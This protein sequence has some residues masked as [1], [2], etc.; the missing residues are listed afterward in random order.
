M[1]EKKKYTDEEIKLIL[2]KF[3]KEADEL[4]TDYKKLNKINT[5]K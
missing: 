2:K 4:I 3:E 1:V 5:L